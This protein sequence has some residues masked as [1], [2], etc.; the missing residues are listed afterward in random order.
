MQCQAF[1]AGVQLPRLRLQYHTGCNSLPT[2]DDLPLECETTPEDMSLPDDMNTDCIYRAGPLTDSWPFYTGAAAD[3]LTCSSTDVESPKPWA[4]IMVADGSE[5]MLMLHFHRRTCGILSVKDGPSENP[6]RTAIWPLA[7][8]SP[9]LYHALTCLTAFHSCKIYPALRMVG[10]KHMH[11]S[12]TSLAASLPRIGLS[13]PDDDGRSLEAALATTLVLAFSE[14]WDQHISTGIKHL[15]GARYFVDQAICRQKTMV[16]QRIANEH[17]AHRMKFLCNSYIYMDVIARL[18]SLEESELADSTSIFDAFASPPGTVAE[19]DPLMGAAR[20]LFP[21]IGHVAS[22]IARVRKSDSNSFTL[23]SDAL[24]MRKMV[25]HWQPPPSLSFA[26]P[27]DP[28]SEV[29]HSLQTAEAYRWATLLYLH[30]SVPEIPS[31]SAAILANR[32][33]KYLATVPLSSRAIILQIYPLL[34]ASC[35]I[36]AEAE[37]TWIRNRW[38][39]MMARMSIG[40]VDKCFEVVKEVW[41]RRDAFE[42]ARTDKCLREQALLDP[43]SDGLFS[44]LTDRSDEDDGLCNIWGNSV[45][46]S[47]DPG[48][49][50]KAS[51]RPGSLWKRRAMTGLPF[52][53]RNNDSGRFD[54]ICLNAG[55]L[56]ESMSQLPSHCTASMPCSMHYQPSKMS[57]EGMDAEYTVRGHLHWLGVMTDF[58]WEGKCSTSCLVSE[59]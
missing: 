10:M 58:G 53:G 55:D 22:I 24:E 33:L 4:Q 30:Q 45:S 47:A 25:E 21:L 49:W 19:I 18:T 29:L 15:K 59:I 5:E 12:V 27:E 46:V 31:E 43:H 11:Q 3:F 23:V 54:A 40:N 9:Q 51:A 50:E 7:Q 48:E 56:E 14:S 37:R 52:R 17:D 8:S 41:A 36:V 57:M 28:T 34:A 20:T 26:T 16:R 1:S 35:E 2:E 6:W 42:A 44:S 39:A 13:Q 38:L 32:V